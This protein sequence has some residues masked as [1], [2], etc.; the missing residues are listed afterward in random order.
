MIP[1]SKLCYGVFKTFSWAFH[2]KCLV[3]A[4]LMRPIYCYHSCVRERVSTQVRTHRSMTIT[5]FRT[6]ATSAGK[7]GHACKVGL[8]LSPDVCQ[9]EMWT[10]LV[11]LIL[12]AVAIWGWITLCCRDV[13]SALEDVQQHPWP[14]P[15]M[16]PVA[17]SSPSSDSCKNVSRHCPVAPTGK[18]D[19][20]Q[21]PRDK[22]KKALCTCN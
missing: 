15:T 19:P 17:P 22:K 16:M 18:I 10:P 14:L 9:E 6:A 13:S 1:N 3:T 21:D 11:Y 2:H 8:L 20:S 4:L 12:S 5:Q 7:E